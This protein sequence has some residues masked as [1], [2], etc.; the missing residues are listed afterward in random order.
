MGQATRVAAGSAVLDIR[1]HIE[2]IVDNS[3]AVVVDVIANLDPA[4]GR[5]TDPL[6]S[7]RGELIQIHVPDCAVV[8]FALCRDTLRV[9]RE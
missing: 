5:G 7:V 2:A 3:V 6:T 9:S 1:R 4:V 8:D